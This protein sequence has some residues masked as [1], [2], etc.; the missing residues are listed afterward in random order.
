VASDYLAIQDSAATGGATFYAGAGSENIND[1]SGWIF[2]QNP[3]GW[4]GNP[5]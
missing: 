3:G 5:A 4:W 2:G 1:N